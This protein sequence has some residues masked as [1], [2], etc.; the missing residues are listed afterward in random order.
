MKKVIIEILSTILNVSP[1]CILPGSSPKTISTWD[2]L[3]QMNII[4]A[5]EDKFNI[6]FSDEQ[7]I[8]MDSFEKIVEITSCK[9]TK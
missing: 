9:L 5:I 1:E 3:A 8:K 7:I 4:L 2:S 6:T